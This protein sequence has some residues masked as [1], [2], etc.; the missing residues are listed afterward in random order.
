M[1]RRIQS[2]WK[3]FGSIIF[4][5]AVGSIAGLLWMGSPDNKQYRL[6]TFAFLG[7]AALSIL[8][9]VIRQ[10]RATGQQPSVG[11]ATTAALAPALTLADADAEG[12]LQAEL[13]RHPQTITL[14]LSIKPNP[15]N[16]VPLWIGLVAL[17][18]LAVYPAITF[19]LRGT[20][21]LIAGALAGALA[22]IL[23]WFRRRYYSQTSLFVDQHEAGLVPAFGRRKA[24]SPATIRNIA[25]RRVRSGRRSVNLLIVVGHDGRAMLA[26][27]GAGFSLEDAALFAAALRVPIDHEWES[28]TASNL[29]HEIP[30]AVPG[31]YRYA[32]ALGALVAGVLCVVILVLTL[33]TGH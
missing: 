9:E 33:R 5:L 14:P 29:D 13:R 8:L 22:I 31:A 19:H 30:G 7:L 4:S 16:A 15:R 17:V 3:R 32:T 12:L 11:D 28:V 23:F 2:S 10:S 27:N 1:F 18:A 24:V 21:L 25:L 26:I 20:G 6:L